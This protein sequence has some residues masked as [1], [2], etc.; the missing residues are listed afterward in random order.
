MRWSW[1]S[2]LVYPGLMSC[3]L[4]SRHPGSGYADLRG[5]DQRWTWESRQRD[6][7]QFQT[8]QAKEDLGWDS[9]YSLNEEDAL[10]LKTRIRLNRMESR[11]LS[12]RE[13][14]QYF[15][16][17]P[18]MNSDSERISFL[19]LPSLE[20][21]ER[22]AQARGLRSGEQG[23]PNQIAELIEKNDIAVGMSPKAVTE[24]WGDPDAVEVA[25]NSMYGNERWR[26]SKYVSSHEGYQKV[27]RLVYFEGGRVAGWETSE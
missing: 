26:Y 16:Y 15:D 22:W 13:R 11:L 7:E 1:F 27:E 21:R 3:S 18:H 17:K 14:K 6:K 25:G 9:G 24:S 10:K 23:H 12:N 2:F 19:S 20:A 8:E 4:L 5:G